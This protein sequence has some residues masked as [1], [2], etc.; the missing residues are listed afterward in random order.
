MSARWQVVAVRTYMVSLVPINVYFSIILQVHNELVACR[1]RMVEYEVH[2]QRSN[3]IS[4]SK[5]RLHCPTVT[6]VEVERLRVTED[7]DKSDDH[8]ENADKMRCM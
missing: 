2:D 6:E 5:I 4:R 8:D 7:R 3:R 1:R